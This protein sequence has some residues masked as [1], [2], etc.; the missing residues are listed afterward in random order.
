MAVTTPK[1]VKIFSLSTCSHCKAAKKFLSDNRVA[2]EFV[3]VDMLTGA[4]RKAAPEEVGRYNPG[5][6][7]PTILI[8]DDVIIGFQ[9]GEMKNALGI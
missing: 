1:R 4:E 2:Y 7:F 9:A 3:D 8:G 6:S 5:Y